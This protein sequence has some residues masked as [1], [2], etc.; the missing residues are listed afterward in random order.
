MTSMYV[1]YNVGYWVVI[2]SSVKQHA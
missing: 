2:K 1:M